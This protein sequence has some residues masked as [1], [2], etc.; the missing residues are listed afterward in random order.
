MKKVLLIV[1]AA[2]AIS[3]QNEGKNEKATLKAS[4]SNLENG[5]EVYL[6]RLG[7]E[8]RPVPIDT[9]TVK[10]GD[11]E[12]DLPAVDFQTL[13]I[14]TFKDVRGNVV[15]IN[16]NQPLT[17]TIYKDSLR[18]SKIE[19]GK[20]N[21]LFNNYIEQLKE[22]GK[23]MNAMVKSFQEENPDM[24]Q[25]PELIAQIRAK[26]QEFQEQDDKKREEIMKN[27]PNSLVSILI[28]SDMLN[29]K[30][31][32]TN[33]AKEIFNNLAEEVQNSEIG[34]SVNKTLE[35]A[36]ATSVG[37]KAPDFSAPTPEGETLALKDAL[38]KVT[39]IDF[40]A[41]W[42][43]PCRMENPNVVKLY[44]EYHEKGLNILGVSLDKDGQKDK[45]L[46]AI[47]DDGL[48]WQHVSNL[49]YWQGPI[50]KLYNIRSIPA[51]FI[52]DENGV[53]VAKDLRGEELKAKVAEMLD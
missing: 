39:I 14:I 28:L 8:G 33:E 19:G 26:Q 24:M 25:N 20:E 38:G 35:Q 36:S 13:N 27:N 17:A 12:I 4:V 50:A 30:S 48:T 46:K 10:E 41:S 40:W 37:S 7:G 9:T 32:A 45:W 1:L 29:S 16:E 2:L 31:I 47:K 44:N 23:E 34:A 3:C 49:K 53:I 11:F 15:F 5:T 43:K 21:E 22:S 6:A 42:C 18:S 52:L 51:T